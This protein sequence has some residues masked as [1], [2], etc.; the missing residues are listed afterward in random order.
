MCKEIR[1]LRADEVEVR[2]AQVTKSGI[3]LLLYKN[4]RVDRKILD[5]VYGP[6]NWQNRFEQIGND[7][8]CTIS[9]YDKEKGQWIDKCDCGTEGSVGDGKSTASDAFKRAAFSLGIGRELYTKLFIFINV[10]TV[11]RQNG[12]GFDVADSHKWVKYSVSEMDVDTENEKITRL[13]IVDDRGGVVFSYPRSSGTRPQV[14]APQT[15]NPP[16]S[17]KN[18]PSAPT[19]GNVKPS[20]RAP[21]EAIDWIVNTYKTGDLARICAKYKVESIQDLTNE[22]FNMIYSNYIKSCEKS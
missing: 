18:E 19:L 3:Q 17:S 4:S 16:Q 21:Q 8:F 5:E 7:L 13:V 20:D 1:A 9:I 15:N 11:A 22:Q 12:K 10:P 2:V 6:L 14:N